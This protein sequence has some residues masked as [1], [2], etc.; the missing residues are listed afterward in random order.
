M[1][2]QHEILTREN[3]KLA[4]KLEQVLRAQGNSSNIIQKQTTDFV[5]DE[6]LKTLPKIEKTS[7]DQVRGP[8]QSQVS[9]NGNSIVLAP[10]QD[11]QFTGRNSPRKTSPRKNMLNSN[12]SFEGADTETIEQIEIPN[13]GYSRKF[14]QIKDYKQK[15]VSD[16]SV[17]KSTNGNSN[18][19]EVRISFYVILGWGF[20]LY[21]SKV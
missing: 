16:S 2:K 10:V 14:K 9:Q 18:S 20:N 5:I 17:N 13:K 6:Q 12:S 7:T 11:G 1:R 3:E 21:P 15:F 19:I 8:L 4:R